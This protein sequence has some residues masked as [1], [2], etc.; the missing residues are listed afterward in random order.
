MKKVIN[1][2]Y[3]ES[4]LANMFPGK[5]INRYNVLPFS[6]VLFTIDGEK[7]EKDL[8]IPFKLVHSD[9]Q[10]VWEIVSNVVYA[11]LQDFTFEVMEIGAKKTFG[12]K[13]YKVINAKGQFGIEIK[14]CPKL[15]NKA[16][17]MQV[18][19]KIHKDY[20]EEFR[21][22]F[23]SELVHAL[24]EGEDGWLVAMKSVGDGYRDILFIRAKD[25]VDIRV[26]HAAKH[27]HY[28]YLEMPSLK[29]EGYLE[30]KHS[31]RK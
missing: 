9:V 7:F 14:D 17:A 22:F 5:E 29:L 20:D 26:R 4:A 1:M 23:Y 21:G 2:D 24:V 28:T 6:R 27:V 31:R 18:W 3:I 30:P 16:D 19:K 8:C 10:Y 12:E 13:T 25:G 15:K 11:N